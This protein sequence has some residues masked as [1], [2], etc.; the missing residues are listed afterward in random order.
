MG[1][2]PVGI[3]AFWRTVLK[4]LKIPLENPREINRFSAKGYTQNYGGA[5]FPK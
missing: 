2:G 3:L 1:S 4:A 5:L